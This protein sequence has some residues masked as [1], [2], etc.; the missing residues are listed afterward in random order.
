MNLFLN[1]ICLI[2][3]AILGNIL[4]VLVVCFLKNKK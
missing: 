2:F 1:I 4:G 3:G